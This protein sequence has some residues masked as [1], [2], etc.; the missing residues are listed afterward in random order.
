M[1]DTFQHGFRY[2][3]PIRTESVCLYKITY[4]IPVNGNVSVSICK[5]PDILIK[6]LVDNQPQAKGTY[7]ITWDGVDSQGKIVS[8]ANDYIIKVE[9][10][11]G[12]KTITRNGNI[13]V[14]FVKR[15][16]KDPF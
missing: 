5:P 3:F 4:S 6:K 10:T 2:S 7:S 11:S 13:T 1:K 9:F 8:E 15:E 16:R 14:D 12:G